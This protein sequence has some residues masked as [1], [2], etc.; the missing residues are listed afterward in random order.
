MDPMFWELHA[1][2][3]REGPGTEA[4]T[5]RA[6]AM[7]G[8]SGPLR[9]LDVASGPGA[10]SRALL[11][12]LPEAQVT[13][14]DLHAPFLV[15][16]AAR[17]AGEG[18]SDRFRIR[19]ADMRDLPFPPESFDLVWCEGAAYIQGVRA[20][21]RAWRSLLRPGGRVAFTEAVWLTDRPHPA[22]RACWGQYAE[23]TDPAGVRGWIA[24]AGFRLVGDFVLSD[25]AWEAYYEPLA[26]R[27]AALE[28]L[29]GADPPVL[30][31]ACEEIAVRGAHGADYGYAFFVAAP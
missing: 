22:A 23:M 5:L 18:G 26:R 2:L 19:E 14:V 13:A 17:V 21:L 27:L 29:R 16:A 6:L 4:D 31:A 9:V 24:D 15:D 3:E 1:G 10:A 12:A 8:L 25:A 30:A 20:A 28:A 7:T 11:G